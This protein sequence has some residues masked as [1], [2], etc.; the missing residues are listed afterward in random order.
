M[1]VVTWLLTATDDPQRARRWE[2]S[3]DDYQTLAASLTA[4][5][6]RLTVLADCHVDAEANID[7][8]PVRSGGNP[9]FHRWQVAAEYL[10]CRS[11]QV[12]CVDGTDT[13]LLELPDPVEVGVAIG[14]EED[15]C[16]SSWMRATSPDHAAWIRAHLDD[17]LLNPGLV[18]GDAAEVARFARSVA[19]REGR[20]M[21]DMAAANIAAR[22]RPF[23]TG[24]PVHTPYKTHSRH[25]GWWRH[26]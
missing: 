13:E 19:A 15:V 11:G 1:H 16:G 25:G 12:W 3:L 9:Y 17:R 14:S 18:G 5:G 24:P 20:D 4:H 7:V 26:K 8:V 10:S 21:T 22:E 6:H 2:P 23:T